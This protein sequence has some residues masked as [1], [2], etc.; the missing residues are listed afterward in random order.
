[1]GNG[2]HG[3]RTVA[4]TATI[5]A[6][7]ALVLFAAYRIAPPLARTIAGISGPSVCR[8]DGVST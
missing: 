1:M 7:L 6:G 8:S 2:S 3:A 5:A 4:R